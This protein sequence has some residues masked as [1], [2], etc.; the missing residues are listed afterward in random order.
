LA[1]LADEIQPAQIVV[2]RE[3]YSL[4]LRLQASVAASRRWRQIAR[5]R[6]HRGAQRLEFELEEEGLALARAAGRGAPR[7]D[8]GA[9][10][11]AL[12][13]A[14]GAGGAA[15]SRGRP[16]VCRA[17]GARL[18]KRSVNRIRDRS[19]FSCR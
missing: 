9:L 18:Y 4:V 3:V 19:G 6:K 5:W 14:R 10:L 7:D 8:R 2:A 17:T 13:G 15:R 1:L 11:D 16:S 12:A